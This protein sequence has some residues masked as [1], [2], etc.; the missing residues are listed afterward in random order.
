MLGAVLRRFAAVALVLAVVAAP[1]VTSTRLF[2]KFTGGEVTGC[3][4][5]AV[6]ALTTIKNAGCCQQRTFERSESTTVL[7]SAQL[8]PPLSAPI[9]EPPLSVLFA[10]HQLLER[11]RIP[12]GA[13]PPAFISHRALLI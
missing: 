6:Q 4:E 3:D 1:A 11:E 7:S 9:A 13:G 5:Q 10:S 12:A 8:T 2:C